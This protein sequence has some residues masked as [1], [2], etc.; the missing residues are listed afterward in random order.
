M[1]TEVLSILLFGQKI[2]MEV[3]YL[4]AQFH[5]PG[6][7]IRVRGLVSPNLANECLNS[8]ILSIVSEMP[9]ANRSGKFLNYLTLLDGNCD[10]IGVMI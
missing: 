1:T 8:C 2:Y 7:G 3:K 4:H 6:S 10:D 9:H 5:R